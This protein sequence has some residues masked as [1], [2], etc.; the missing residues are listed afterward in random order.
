MLG[1]P[2]L[3]DNVLENES[4]GTAYEMETPACW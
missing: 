4:N 2:D 1:L 3:N